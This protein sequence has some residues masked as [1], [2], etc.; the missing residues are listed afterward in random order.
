MPVS[1][2]TFGDIGGAVSDL[3]SGY[4]QLQ[5]AKGYAKAAGFA[6]QNAE[7]AKQ[8]EAIQELQAQRKVYQ[9]IGGQQADVAGAGLAASGSA[10]D[11]LRDSAQQGA[12]TVQLTKQQGAINVAGYE[13]EAASYSSMASAAKAAG[14]G[15]ILG[16][17]VKGAAALFAFSDDRL[18]EGVTLESRRRDGLGIYTFA[19]KGSD[20]RFRGV[21]ASEVERIYPAAVTWDDGHRVVNYSVIGVK[22]EVVN[23]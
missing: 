2:S 23:A 13:A 3:F 20:Q 22:P 6:Q 18:K 9:T 17:L 8:S 11:L 21:L 10:L 4:G 1:A 5:S 15:S 16:G 14:T 7:I 12:L 19:F